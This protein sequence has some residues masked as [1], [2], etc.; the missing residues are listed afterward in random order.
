MVSSGPFEDQ[1]HQGCNLGQDPYARVDKFAY[2]ISQQEELMREEVG[3]ADL[4]IC[5]TDNNASRFI[6]SKALVDYQ[7][8]GIFGRAITRAGR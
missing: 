7:K 3:K 2:D 5:A 6:L 4:V 1:C 8:V